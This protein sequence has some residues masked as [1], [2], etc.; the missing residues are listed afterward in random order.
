MSSQVINQLKTS[1]K[2]LAIIRK[3][4]GLRLKRYRCQ[5]GHWTIGYGHKL[6]GIEL[7]TMFA[8][9]R[10]QAETMLVFDVQVPEIYINGVARVK[11]TQNQF[12]ALVSF[13][14]N[15]GVGKL[16]NSSLWRLLQAG[17]FVAAA[18]EFDKWIHYQDPVS[19]VMKKSNGLIKR[20]DDEKA[21]FLKNDKEDVYDRN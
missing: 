12:D 11:L 4:E 18:A 7:K 5:A 15:F 17:N 21:L 10:E 8:I 6:R 2:G 16:E 1:D 14:F 9:T 3:H 13:A 20:R 19:K